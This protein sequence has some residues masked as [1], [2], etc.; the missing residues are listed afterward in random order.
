MY[1]HPN[2]TYCSTII[3]L[4]P[5]TV[6]H[7][8]RCHQ[9]FLRHWNSVEVYAWSF[10]AI[11]SMLMKDYNVFCSQGKEN[12][13][14]FH[15]INQYWTHLKS[16]RCTTHSWPVLW[17]HMAEEHRMLKGTTILHENSAVKTSGLPRCMHA[18]ARLTAN[19]KIF[20]YV[21]VCCVYTAYRTR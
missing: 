3:T 5:H 21:C 16:N 20:V 11:P 10:I 7:T 17:L 19:F 13:E 8:Q 4:R 12:Q 18:L 1:R 9:K 2:V 15:H 14:H 6:S